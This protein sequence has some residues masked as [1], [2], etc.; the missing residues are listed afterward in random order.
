MPG[1]ASRIYWIVLTLCIVWS[2]STFAQKPALLPPLSGLDIF[3]PVPADNPLRAEVVE[4]GR[5][6][7][8]DTDL[9]ADSIV[10]CATCHQP[11]KGFSN[12]LAISVGVFD[13]RG[14]RNVPAIL[15]RG[16]GKAFFWDGRIESL[17]EQV[18]QPIIAFDEM[19]MTIEELLSQL[20]SDP[21]YST[22]FLEVFSRSVNKED[23]GRALAS[24]VRT[25]RAGSS[26]F[27]RFTGGDAGALTE[28]E[29]EGLLLFQGKAR[30][31][32]CHLGS[33][34]SDEGFH[35]TGVAWING[36]LLDSGRALV[37]DLNRDRGAFK[38]PTL[39]QIT[40]TAPYM[41]DGSLATLEE[42]VDF[43]DQG[44]NPNPELDPLIKPL[45]LNSR[46]KRAL[47]AFLRSL[48]GSVSEG[49]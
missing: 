39:R 38:T 17:E 21:F 26:A 11:D 45:V 36:R 20:Q 2:D 25:I 43:Y 16:Y 1:P 47:I 46:E 28:M 32:R 37:T 19:G 6:L 8:F 29:K 44:G 15:N 10:S 30:C 42:V 23:L 22:R 13:R 18:L 3:M 49:L 5:R 33:N 14:T 24:Y 35:N 41:H 12:E 40:I 31:D 34:L 27:D 9:S 48:S 4:L 7:F